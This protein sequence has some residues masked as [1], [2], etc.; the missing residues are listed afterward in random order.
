M[1]NQSYNPEAIK[2]LIIDDHPQMRKAIAK[3]L[4][5]LDI[6][7]IFEGNSAEE[8]IAILNK[9]PVDL[10][11][12]DLY[13]I[14]SLG[15]E[16][17]DYVRRREV[18]SDV[19]II[20]VTGEASKEDI[21]KCVDVGAS[22]YLLKPFQADDLKNKAIKLL[23]TYHA[24]SPILRLTRKAERMFLEGKF[25]NALV[26][27][28]EALQKDA[29]AVGLRYLKAITLDK[30]G[31]TEQ[32]LKILKENA[33]MND[34]FYKTFASLAEIYLRLKR[35]EEAMSAII[36]ELELNPK[37]AN[38]QTQLGNLLLNNGKIE[39]SIEHFRLALVENVKHRL[40]L[41][42]MGKAYSSSGN[43]DKAIYYY[44]RLRRYYP[45]NTKALE[46]I[47]K[48][49][50]D[51]DDPKRAEMALRDEK[52]AHKT[53]FDTYLVLAKFYVVTDRKQEAIDSLKEL[54]VLQP[55]DSSALR[56]LAAIH[57]Q[58]SEFQPA[59]DIYV[60]LIKK[61]DDYETHIQYVDILMHVK[62]YQEAIQL[63]HRCFRF[64]YNVVD[65][66]SR[67]ATCYQL[68]GELTKSC[69]IHQ[70]LMKELPSDNQLNQNYQKCIA[71]LLSRRQVANKRIA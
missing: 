44:K 66:N 41:F 24:P 21:V 69:L 12:C 3:I 2:V 43:L 68:S 27:V 10:I 19:P 38:R 45:T 29:K 61:H 33:E 4:A 20:I 17:I 34:S 30:L 40:A 26:V 57:V 54:L 47:V 42:G 13:L 67:L 63:L 35:P 39:E 58:F 22:D 53:R 48:C 28:D 5:K 31:Q 50:L 36:K 23:N 14:D 11:I 16:V 32:A 59:I 65:V 18:D 15:F 62:K 7:Q 70:K 6:G 56:L 51:A 25:A 9:E 71:T 46:A 52:S 60:A 49:C 37:Q 1:S 55:E 64:Q 8:A